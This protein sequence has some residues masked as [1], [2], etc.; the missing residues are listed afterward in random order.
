MTK[1]PPRID[2]LL[3]QEVSEAAIKRTWQGVHLKR[4]QR[5]QKQRRGERALAIATV[6]ALT[7]LALSLRERSAAPI[8]WSQGGLPGLMQTQQAKR[9]VR[10]DDGS[11]ILLNENTELVPLKNTPTAFA[12]H[13]LS[14]R[15]TFEVQPKGPRIWSIECGLATVE[16][17]GTRFS[18]DRTASFVRI[19][20]ERGRVLVT[21]ERV[22]DRART[23]GPKEKIIIHQAPAGASKTRRSAPVRPPALKP[24]RPPKIAAS[25]ASRSRSSA[26]GAGRTARSA[27]R[28]GSKI[29]SA[30]NAGKAR[31]TPPNPAP[32]D[33]ATA[34]PGPPK[35]S[36]VPGSPKNAETSLNDE[37][38]KE[39]GKQP[40]SY[41]ALFEQGRFQEAYQVAEAS[42][43][44][45]QSPDALLLLADIARLSGH[46][47]RA[48]SVLERLLYDHPDSKQAPVAAFTL[49]RVRLEALEQPRRAAAAFELA[50]RRG[51]PAPLLEDAFARQVE[52]LAKA[53]D[54]VGAQAAADR[55]FSRYP[56]GR[57]AA[58]VERWVES[59]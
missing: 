46:P 42:I 35:T 21:G 17:L 45:P 15:A 57:R 2:D 38:T 37:P 31:P 54:R 20:V 16:V 43:D 30:Q 1:L 49:G 22:P 6:C 24:E 39:P 13:L 25:P 18:V 4:A 7:V 32:T 9:M 3:H 23:L 5:M 55:Y 50:V 36:Q 47:N 19:E 29:A 41:E 52:A 8:E 48:A 34:P 11:S 26:Q 10:F 53:G 28:S 33:R 51:L 12:L 59:R 58:L 56:K 27:Q 40:A 44:Q 14:G